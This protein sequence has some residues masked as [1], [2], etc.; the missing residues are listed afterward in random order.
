M[1]RRATRAV[2]TLVAGPSPRWT[3]QVLDILTVNSVQRIITHYT[4]RG[5]RLTN[6]SGR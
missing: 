1:L 4:S 2:L 3:P 6:P 5:Y